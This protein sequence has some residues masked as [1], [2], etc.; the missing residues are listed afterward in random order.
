MR[1]KFT[2]LLASML[3]LSCEKYC[4]Q[5]VDAKNASVD[6][7]KEFVESGKECRD[8]SL[9]SVLAKA[10]NRE[11]VDYLLSRGYTFEKSGYPYLIRQGWW[12]LVPPDITWEYPSDNVNNPYSGLCGVESQEV[13]RKYVEKISD[14]GLRG[15]EGLTCL[16]F[17]LND[18]HDKSDPDLVLWRE[19]IELILEKGGDLSA[20]TESGKTPI[21]FLIEEC[22]SYADDYKP[23]IKAKKHT[24]ELVEKHD[25][26]L[27]GQIRQW[28]ME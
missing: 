21:D 10:G 17:R 5:V 7:I 3:L 6:E 27:S 8:P 25:I 24:L 18:I 22:E 2:I 16:H 14:A 4:F 15:R 9:L 26:E 11:G 1:G 12:D 20:K 13:F 23:C 28:L 19:N